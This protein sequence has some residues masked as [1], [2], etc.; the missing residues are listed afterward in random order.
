[1]AHLLVNMYTSNWIQVWYQIT[2]KYQNLKLK[3][4]ALLEG[5]NK[6]DYHD[7]ELS[8][9]LQMLKFTIEVN[10]KQLK[11]LLLTLKQL[12]VIWLVNFGACLMASAYKHKQVED[13]Y[14][15][16]SQMA[17][18]VKRCDTLRKQ[19]QWEG[20]VVREV[21]GSNPASILHN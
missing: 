17:K 7:S 8:N 19:Q 15:N 5:N 2:F 21:A 18:R 4:I 10:N 13:T 16:P 12:T 20:L 11:W 9:C 6:I 3:L 1:L 14:N